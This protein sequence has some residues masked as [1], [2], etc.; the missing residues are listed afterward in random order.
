MTRRNM[1]LGVAGLVLVLNAHQL[2]AQTFQIGIID[3][4]GLHRVSASDARRALTFTEGDSIS[5]GDEPPAF[6]ADSERRLAALPG[7]ERARTNIVCCDQGRIIIYVGVEEKG[8]PT[9]HVRNAPTGTVRLPAD[10]VQ[11]GE[12][13]SRVFTVAV[14]RGV[15]TE[16][17]SSGHALSHDP[18]TRAVQERFVGFAAR[19]PDLLRRVLRESSDAGQRGLAAQVMGYAADKQ[20]V[21]DDLVYGMTDPSENVRNNCMRTL[22]VFTDMPATAGKSTPRVPYDP[23]VALLNSLVWTDRN[24]SSLAL[25]EL[26]ASRDPK[27]LAQLRREAM[28]SLVDIARW[29]NEGHARPGLTILGRIAG[30]DDEEVDAAWSNGER[31]KVI[32][33]AQTS[34]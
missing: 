12:E 18:A 24:K 30:W 2:S 21:V 11:A 22:L 20:S 8:A 4:Y 1:T 31:E 28:P 3:F 33:A 23:F 13:F 17:R 26:T 7:V 29:K 27:L 19:D 14:E 16:D 34:R 6:L 5:L 32:E 10:V 9:L 15:A 25:M